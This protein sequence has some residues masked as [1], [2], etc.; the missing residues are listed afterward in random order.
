M[1]P[2]LLVVDF[3]EEWQDKKSDYYLGQFKN[4]LRN[5]RLL[6]EHFHRNGWPVIL[7]RHVEVGSTTAFAEGTKNTQIA[8]DLSVG[9]ADRVITKNKISPFYNTEL[10]KMLKELATDELVVGGIMTNLCVR[11]A[12]SDAY[13][14]GYRIKVVTDACVSDS[15]EV[16]RFTFKDLKKTRPEVEFV[17]TKEFVAPK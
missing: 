4:Q 14:R 9:P 10:E 5:T 1:P 12:V 13:D 11:S 6:I 3:Q 15:A 17:K 7:T 8:S 16:D 2:V